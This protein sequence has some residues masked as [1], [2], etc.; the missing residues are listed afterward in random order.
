MAGAALRG[1]RTSATRNSDW[2]AR[3]VMDGKQIVTPQAARSS[4]FD[5]AFRSVFVL[6][7]PR[8]SFGAIPLLG[9][10]LSPLL[11]RVLRAD[12]EV[13]LAAGFCARW[14]ARRGTAGGGPGLGPNGAPRQVVVAA[15]SGAPWAIA[16]ATDGPIPTWDEGPRATPKRSVSAKPSVVVTAGHLPSRQVRRT[17]SCVS[18]VETCAWFPP[19]ASRWGH[20]G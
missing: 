11:S 7:R 5:Q 9:G 19:A 2:R 13:R 3:H 6:A 12:G 14:R 8:S 18:A 16:A 4:R 17:W 15:P 1:S 20:S 10:A